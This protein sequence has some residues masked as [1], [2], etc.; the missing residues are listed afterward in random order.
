MTVYHYFNLWSKRR[1]FEKAFEDLATSYLRTSPAKPLVVDTSFVKNIYGVEVVG[2]N[3]TDGGRKATKVSLLCDE[4]GAPLHVCYHK[5]NK[6]DCQ[7]LGHLLSSAASKY[8]PLS[9]HG[10]LLADKGY[11]SA[12]CRSLCASHSLQQLIPKRRE[13]QDRVLNGRRC[14]VERVF[15]QIDRFWRVN[16]TRKCT[17]SGSS[18]LW[19]A[20]WCFPEFLGHWSLQSRRAVDRFWRC[21]SS[22]LPA[23]RLELRP[24]HE[25]HQ[26]RARAKLDR[27]ARFAW[28]PLWY[29][30]LG[31]HAG[32]R[33]SRARLLRDTQAR[34]PG[35]LPISGTMT[36]TVG[37]RLAVADR[38][39]RA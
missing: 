35:A 30:S 3:P 26:A 12:Q 9:V 5:A 18:M 38:L 8:G 24:D 28:R 16:T 13:A 15:N 32:E 29:V 33:S 27:S 36:E 2:R 21:K 14:V 31:K 17:A 22:T 11:D 20:L 37:H 19:R 7:T 1:V 39:W 6:S 10:E 23:P 4:R 25:A 34:P